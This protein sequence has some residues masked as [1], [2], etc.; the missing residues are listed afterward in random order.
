MMTHLRCGVISPCKTRQ[1]TLP[2][3]ARGVRSSASIRYRPPLGGRVVSFCVFARFANA[4]AKWLEAEPEGDAGQ[5]SAGARAKR[6]GFTKSDATGLESGPD[7]VDYL[8]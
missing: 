8:P 2:R 5:G 3:L 1:V 4:G 7:F 6:S